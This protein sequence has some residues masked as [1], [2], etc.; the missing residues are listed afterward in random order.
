MS[1]IAFPSERFAAVA[2]SLE[3]DAKEWM[4]AFGYPPGWDDALTCRMIVR[5]WCVDLLRSNHA[6]S[7][8]QYGDLDEHEGTLPFAHP[9]PRV[10]LYKALCAIRY[11][12]IANDGTKTS[13]NKCAD[14]L[15]RVIDGLAHRIIAEMD[16]YKTASW[17]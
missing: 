5:A 17:I 8:R 7:R 6:T 3:T 16:E 12:L 15:D 4:W 13:L 14:I 9:L 11:N 10:A 1:V 2:A